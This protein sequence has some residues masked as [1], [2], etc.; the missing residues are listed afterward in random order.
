FHRRFAIFQKNLEEAKRLQR[1]ERGTAQYGITKFSDL[2]D[3]EFLRCR[4]DHRAYFESQTL[5]RQVTEEN[6]PVK[7]CDWRKKGVISVPKNQGPSCLSCYAFAAVGNIEAQWGIWGSPKNLSVQQLV[8][9]SKCGCQGGYTWNAF[10]TVIKIGGLT[11]EKNYKYTGKK[12]TCKTNLKPEAT[13]QDFV[14][15]Q[16]NETVI[17]SHV[18]YKG[19]VTV[20]INQTLLKQYQKGVIDPHPEKCDNNV[21]H[22]VLIVGFSREKKYWILKNS[23]GNDWGENG[24]FRLRLGSNACGIAEYP[25]SAIVNTGTFKRHICPP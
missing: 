17:C 23:W 11:N 18:S 22:A 16:R 24:F 2:T 20:A 14:I 8:D 19:T 21:D 5:L 6:A 25:A 15:L 4:P 13:I 12:S 9:C 3:E 10:M 7:T 1:E